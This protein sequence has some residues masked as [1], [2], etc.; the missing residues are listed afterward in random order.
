MSQAFSQAQARATFWLTGI[1]AVWYLRVYQFKIY[2]VLRREKSP[3]IECA[4]RTGKT[5]TILT[6]VLELLRQNPGWVCRYCVPWKKQAREIVMP[7]MEQIQ[8]DC[9]EH[10]RFKYK[11][12][13]SYYEGPPNP[14]GGRRSR[15]YLIGL[16]DDRGESARGPFA[17]IIV[18]DEYGTVKDVKYI[19][20]D[21]LR[22]QLLGQQGQ[23]LLKSGTPP[24]NLGHPYY[25]EKARAIRLGRYV[26]LTINDNTFLTEA[27]HQGIIE[28]SG[29]E[30]S[31][32][33]RREYLCE[34]VADPNLLV[35]PEFNDIAYDKNGDILSW[36]HCI[37]DDTPRPEF[38]SAWV[39]G[40]SG[41]DD[42]TALIFSYYDFEEAT[43]VYED[44]I[45][46]AGKTTGHITR[47]AKCKEIELWAKDRELWVQAMPLA[48]LIDVEKQLPPNVEEIFKQIDEIHDRFIG[49][50]SDVYRHPKKRVYDAD[51]QLIFD[52]Y[53][54]S[55]SYPM[56]MAQKKDKIASIHKYRTEWSAGRIKIKERCKHT[57]RQHAV[58]IWKDERKSDFERAEGLGHLDCISAG[59][60]L[61]RSIDRNFNP[62]PPT[63]GVNRQTQHVPAGLTRQT[64][65]E[66]E[67]ALGN[68][69]GGRR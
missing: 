43:L 69:F 4:R 3:F 7:E 61:N 58:G 56:Q 68:I 34:E 41:A 1:I 18:I 33:Y 10:L 24:K 27:E 21:I 67:K 39:G 22:P 50:M 55:Y 46:T 37:P 6:F 52:L 20:R 5:T 13:D 15:L 31:T 44:E 12:T 19:E 40:D 63:V 42:N 62:I 30:D 11:T 66:T 45:V 49:A 64:V 16:N 17:N 65:S 32:T 48:A 2:D 25:D 9:P 60:Y 36:G 28:E 38:F 53:G 26:K 59:L 57:R 23:Y 51:K 29:G 54:S 47:L 14:D 35:I 8:K